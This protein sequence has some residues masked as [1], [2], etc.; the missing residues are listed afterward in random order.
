MCSLAL[1]MSAEFIW[2]HVK[3]PPNPMRSPSDH[4]ICTTIKKRPQMTFHLRDPETRVYIWEVWKFFT[5]MK[6]RISNAGIH[7]SFMVLKLYRGLLSTLDAKRSAR[8]AGERV[9]L[10]GVANSSRGPRPR[11]PTLSKFDNDFSMWFF[12]NFSS[13]FQNLLRIFCRPFLN[14][15]Q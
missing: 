13:N 10:D 7:I 15:N 12:P 14:P 2:E 11:F 6:S 4:A 8:Q 5:N 3:I 1:I 9:V